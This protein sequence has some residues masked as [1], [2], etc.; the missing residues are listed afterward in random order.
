MRQ[1][2]SFCLLLLSAAAAAQ[3]L[4]PVAL[5]KP[6]T[7]GGKPLMEALAQRK[8]TREYS[9]EKLSPQLLSN[10]L[11]AGFGVNRAD[12][13]RTAPS[14]VNWQETDIYVVTAE[15]LY[16]Y[17][18]KGHALE[19]VAS[20]DLRAL[21]GTQGFVQT[22]PLNLVYVADQARMR[23]IPSLEGQ[24]MSAVSV[25]AISQNVSLYC[26]SEGLGTVV[27]ASIDKAAFAK[28]A[29]LRSDQIVILAQTVG[30]PKK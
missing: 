6:Q 21:A 23:K 17:D 9:P 18:A 11:W 29:N 7:T 19:P 30:Y 5:P 3:E 2:L 4:K 15:G 14:A 26:A 13:R 22:A 8:S 20:G 12:G 16:R 27:R 1:T 28:A 24:V 10:L 25:G